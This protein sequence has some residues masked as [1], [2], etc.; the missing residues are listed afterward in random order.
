[1]CPYC[2]GLLREGRRLGLL[3]AARRAVATDKE[4]PWMNVELREHALWCHSEARLTVR[5]ARR[6]K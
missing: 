1:M 4:L 3:A 5:P 6:K 2:T